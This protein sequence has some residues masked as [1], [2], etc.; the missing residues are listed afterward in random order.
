MRKVAAGIAA[1]PTPVGTRIH[2]IHR[3]GIVD[4][5][6]AANTARSGVARYRLQLFPPGT[7]ADELRPLV[8]LRRW[9]SWGLG[10][11]FALE[12]VAPALI[13]G[14]TTVLVIAA[15]YLVVLGVL[16]TATARLRSQTGRMNV[17]VIQVAPDT[18]GNQRLLELSRLVRAMMDTDA[19]LC[20][21]A[22]DAVEYEAR[23]GIVYDELRAVNGLAAVR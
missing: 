9:R 2:G 16:L 18:V 7:S 20:V 8:Q 6:D 17:A 19:Q 22:I 12:V 23:W 11:A 10:A 1:R 15:V 3:W 14:W 4:L 13:P 5:P 21:G